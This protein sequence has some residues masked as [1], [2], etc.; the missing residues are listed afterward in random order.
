MKKSVGSC[1]GTS[2]MLMRP[3]SS[4][5]TSLAHLEANRRGSLRGK[6]QQQPG[7]KA[8]HISLKHSDDRRA[9]YSHD[10]AWHS[11]VLVELSDY[12]GSQSA[13][14]R[15]VIEFDDNVKQNVYYPRVQLICDFG[16]ISQ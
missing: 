8:S 12:I 3:F 6:R 13:S 1:G 14:A 15:Y 9:P 7:H 11:V 4:S 5:L 10:C 16:S 2:P